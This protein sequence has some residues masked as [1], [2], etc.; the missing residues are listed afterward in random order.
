MNSLT[1]SLLGQTTKSIV[2]ADRCAARTA[3]RRDV[4]RVEGERV[5]G[6]RAS[7]KKTWNHR[8][9]RSNRRKLIR[10]PPS[11]CGRRELEAG[12]QCRET[13]TTTRVAS[14]S[15]SPTRLPGYQLGENDVP[16]A[17]GCTACEKHGVV[18]RMATPNTGRVD[19]LHMGPRGTARPVS[20]AYRLVRSETRG[21]R[22][23]VSTWCLVD[24]ICGE[25]H[26]GTAS[27]AKNLLG[28]TGLCYG[29]AYQS[30]VS[31]TPLGSDERA[32]SW[33][34]ST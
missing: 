29:R 31:Q 14:K 22:L 24:G 16:N 30:W 5:A 3:E 11:D 4:G 21:E 13:S 27:G 7:M 15:G 23:G 17:P 25:H 2:D 9:T 32:G 33:W 1:T 18:L 6:S 12:L 34:P 26:A 8:S 10:S 20:P 28:L 19:D